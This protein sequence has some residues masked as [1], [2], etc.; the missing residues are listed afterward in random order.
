MSERPLFRPEVAQGRHDEWLGSI[1][2]VSPPS[3][4]IPI[5]FFSTVAAALL[6]FLIIGQYTRRESVTG[7][8]VPSAG[9]LTLTATSAG[10]IV[11]IAVSE[12]QAVK[13]GDVLMEVASHQDSAALGDTHELVGH[14]L[15][16]QRAALQADL[17]TQAATTRQQ[18]GALQTK[19]TLLQS[20]LA[21]IDD[22]LTI[23]QR[24]VMSNQALLERIR[25]LAS[26]GYVSALQIQQQ[27][28]T[29]LDAQ[30]QYKALVRQKLD[31]RQQ[32]AA[33][34]Q[35]RAQLPLD[36]ASKRNDTERQLASVGQSMAQNEA[37]RAVVL[38]APQDGVISTMLPKEGQMVASGQPLV[39][40]LPSGS[41]LQAQLFVP[42]RAIGF[43]EPGNR[44]VLRYQ[45]YPFQK[46]GQQYGTVGN[47]SRSALSPSEA[48]GLIG[49]QVNEPVYRIQVLLD[50][51]HVQAYGKPE[52]IKPGM[53]LEADILMERRRLIEWVFEPLYGIGHRLLEGNAHG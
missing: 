11:R 25:P 33:T 3:R 51:Q 2:V 17:T 35:Q 53:V 29:V 46:F 14:Q 39:S 21:Q 43:I 13:A 50:Q 10:T 5:A 38:R 27:E 9:L 40:I 44:V 49:Q 15:E 16:S 47:V 26:K 48:G 8:L 36:A 24:Q 18:H 52:P 7:Q 30:T 12:G 19:L 23:Q 42:S 34:Q 45:A 31:T 32:I 20:Q 41:K 28:T 4:W 22:Q 6:L 37:E 1:I